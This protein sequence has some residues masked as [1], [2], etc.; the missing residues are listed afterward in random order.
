M[1]AYAI[2]DIHGQLGKLEHAHM[3]IQMD[4]ELVADDEAPVVH[5]G[6]LVNRGPDARGVLD[7]LIRGQK[8]GKPWVV[9][10]GNHDRMMAWFLEDTPRRDHRMR[11]EY[12]WLNP[13]IGGLETLASYG[14]NI[15]ADQSPEAIHAEACEKVPETHKIFMAGLASSYR[16]EDLFFCHAGIRPGVALEDQVE[17][18]LC[19]IREE[20]YASDADHGALIIHGHTPV[21]VVT[22]YGNRLN[23]D[24][25][26]GFG[27]DL[28]AVV[29]EDGQV[30]LL[31]EQGRIRIPVTQG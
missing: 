11:V 3:L 14:V 18:D 20:F 28:S 9:L 15:T 25:G 31:S 1:R 8:A 21:D 4:R 10:K 6:D 26:A 29:I 17:D 7:F 23:T 12:E 16:M 24:T 5:I 2:G 13:R 22:H 30:W 27:R 19:W